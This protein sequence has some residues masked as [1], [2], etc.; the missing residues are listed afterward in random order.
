MK[1][2]INEDLKEAL[3]SG[4]TL[5]RDVLRMLKARILEREVSLR[6]EKGKDYQLSSEEVLQVI[7]QYAKQRKQ[8]IS[9]FQDGGRADLAEKE[10]AE[11]EILED[12]L[13]KALSRE[14]IEALVDEVISASGAS[15][16][17]DLGTVMKAVMARTRGAADGKEV[18]Q[19]VRS[20]LASG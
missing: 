6:Q 11:L 16:P 12:Y 1:D 8:S 17:A 2:R 10:Q 19:I 7:Q 5:R 14:E 9:S 3:K 15:G 20:K 13:P 18:N 4:D